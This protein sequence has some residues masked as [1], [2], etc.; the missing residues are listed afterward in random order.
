MSRRTAALV[1]A[2]FCAGGA[3][4]ALAHSGTS[5]STPRANARVATLPAT[6]TIA[7][8]GQVGLVKSITVV[9]TT[10]KRNYVTGF[11]TDPRNASRAVARL[12]SVGPAGT[13]V[14]RW[15]VNAA[16]GHLQTGTF[17]FS[18]RRAG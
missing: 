11:G 1:V 17:R 18:T 9:N 14:V 13:Y 12:R 8:S 7:F 6:V 5:G 4:A 10:T 2:V 3:P 16:D 15:Q